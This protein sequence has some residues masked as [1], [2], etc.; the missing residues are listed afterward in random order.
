VK[1]DFQFVA[2]LSEEFTHLFSLSDGELAS[3]GA[4]RMIVDKNPGYPCRVSLIDAAI[5]ETVILTTY[6]HHNTESPYQASGPIF[7]REAARTARTEV[8]KIP[9]M[10]EHRLLSVRAYNKNA[11]MC[12]AKVVEGHDLEQAIRDFFTDE[13]IAYIHIHNAGPGCF[14]CLVNR[15]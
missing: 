5:G 9:L 1:T 4:R 8:N 2:I 10:F 12:G 14:N 13:N 11:M 7:V 3:Y 15:A 6:R